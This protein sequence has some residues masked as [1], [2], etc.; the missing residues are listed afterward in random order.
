MRRGEVRWHTFRPPDKK[1]PVLIIT[2]NSVL[3]LL[4]GIT[5]AQLT[6]NIRG[7]PTEVLLTPQEDGVR[8]VCVVNLD[9]IQT[10]QKRSLGKYITT[11]SEERMSDVEKAIC[12]ALD[13]DSH[14][15]S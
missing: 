15:D 9:N 12:F 1:R 2:R 5:V 13:I 11:L 10:V 4:T 14:S 7:I 3:G 8:A 6:T